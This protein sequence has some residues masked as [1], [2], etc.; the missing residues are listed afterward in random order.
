MKIYKGTHLVADTE[1]DVVTLVMSNQEVENLKILPDDPNG[2]ISTFGGEAKDRKQINEN[3]FRHW[4]DESVRCYW[5]DHE[6]TAA[7]EEVC[8]EE[9]LRAS[10]LASY[11]DWSQTPPYYRED[12]SDNTVKENELRL[13]EIQEELRER[14]YELPDYLVEHD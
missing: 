4:Y 1:T 9:D 3:I 10:E 8:R 6:H 14:G 11:I 2:V 7:S 12:T 5:E 13:Y